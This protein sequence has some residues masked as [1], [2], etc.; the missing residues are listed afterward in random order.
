[1]IAD[2]T[3]IPK[4]QSDPD[5]VAVDTQVASVHASSTHHPDIQTPALDNPVIHTPIPPSHTVDTK[6]HLLLLEEFLMQPNARKAP[7][8]LAE[9]IADDF[10]EF[11]TTG[12]VYN[13]ANVIEWLGKAPP[14][15]LVPS[16]MHC[17]FLADNIAQ[18]AYRVTATRLD[19][20]TP[21]Q[22]KNPHPPIHTP[23]IHTL[24]S[25]LWRFDGTRWQVFFHQAT[26]VLQ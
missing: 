18:I 17:M 15:K 23:P 8:M 3:H 6:Q 4:E 26:V 16:Q 22:T 24:R 12:R 10:V 19:T 14:T 5:E 2:P 9:L 25:S 11:G 1:M 7:A 13:K 20:D 21:I